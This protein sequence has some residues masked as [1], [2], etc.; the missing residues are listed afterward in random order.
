MNYLELGWKNILDLKLYGVF[1][2]LWNFN[3]YL[4]GFLGGVGVSVVVVF[5]FI[6]FGSD[7]GGFI[8]IF[9]FWIGIVGLKFFRGVIIGNFNSVKG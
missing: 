7:V 6:V 4:G 1:V 2:N 5:V 9:V 8:C 3:Y